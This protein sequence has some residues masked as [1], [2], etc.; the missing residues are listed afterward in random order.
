MLTNYRIEHTECDFKREV[1]HSKPK[2]WLKSVCAFANGIGGILVFGIDDKTRQ[3]V[4][5]VDIQLEIEFITARI[6]SF[7]KN[8]QK[9][10]KPLKFV[11][12]N[13]KIKG[14]RLCMNKFY[15]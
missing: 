1:E 5:L 8:L 12:P 9:K 7:S 6:S 10:R 11:L 15:L 4:P 14:I 2:S 13:K 3:H